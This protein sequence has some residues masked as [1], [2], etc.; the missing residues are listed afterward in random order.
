M[1]G[2]GIRLDATGGQLIA[3]LACRPARHAL[4]VAALP[5]FRN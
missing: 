4:A 1:E 2:F 3:N 5:G